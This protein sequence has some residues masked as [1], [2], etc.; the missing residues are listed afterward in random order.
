MQTP[1]WKRSLGLLAS[2]ALL[3]GWAG[4][5]QTQAQKSKAKPKPAAK[6]APNSGFESSYIDRM[7]NA[8]WKKENVTPAPLVDDAR[9]LRR[10]SLDI[11]GVIPTPERV[12]QFLADKSPSKRAEVIEELLASPRYAANWSNYW[13]DVLMGT[14]SKSPLVDRAEFKSWLTKQFAQNVPYNK[15]VYSLITATGQNSRGGTYA[16]AAGAMPRME[17]DSPVEISNTSGTLTATTDTINGATNWYLKYAQTPAE[18]SGAASKVFLGVQISCA[19]CHDHKTEKW[20]QDDFRRF[21]ACFV[22]ARPVPVVANPDKKMIRQVELRD[23]RRPVRRLNKNAGDDAG[24]Y[25]TATPT[26]LDGTNFED[27]PNRRAA[28]AEWIT[29]EK[30]PYFADAIVNRM[31]AHFMGRGFIDPIDDIRPSNPATMQPL[32]KK[33][34]ADF[35]GSE[36]DLKHL[37]RTICN[38]RT[39][40]LAV[41]SGKNIGNNQ[42][43]AQYRLRPMNPDQLLDS[44]VA[45]TNMTSM[46]D[47]VTGG[48]LETVKFAIKRQFTFLFDVDEEFE[49]KD[50]E[51]TI[52]QALLLMN[53]PLVSSAATPL[54]QTAMASIMTLP[55]DDAAKIEAMYLRTLSRKPTATEQKKWQEFLDAPREV[56]QTKAPDAP[57]L[58]GKGG[59]G[60]LNKAGGGADPLNR[61]L[62]G[63]NGRPGLLAGRFAGNNAIT[64][65]QQAFEDIFWALLNSSEFMFNH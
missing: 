8:E 16:Q 25:L 5:V 60:K 46:L 49:Q 43:W 61:P 23:T 57:F 28:L 19:Q 7:L 52:P 42:L 18:L 21:T 50:F 63:R 59:T 56:V 53:G 6:E 20:K 29:A 30:N 24:S 36:Y 58:R 17:A 54:P 44:L 62:L 38:S 55:G 35:I 39:Y 2:G 48:N 40:Q 34:S 9:F 31:W 27:A 4:T 37:M 1:H 33:L 12:T 10:V 3:L 14:Q 65:K 13:N 26:A 51:G 32:L 41:G 64:P 22:Q 11:T 15:F 45:A 47:R